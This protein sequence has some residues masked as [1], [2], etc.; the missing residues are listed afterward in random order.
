MKHTFDYHRAFNRSCSSSLLRAKMHFSNANICLTNFKVKQAVEIDGADF[1]I[2]SF[3]VGC[4]KQ[5]CLIS[6]KKR[7]FFSEITLMISLKHLPN[8][9]LTYDEWKN[10]E[11]HLFY[12]LMGIEEM[13]FVTRCY[14]H[15]QTDILSCIQI[16]LIHLWL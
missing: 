15:F 13:N 10:G 16:I 9:Q 14:S 11:R 8:L 4:L 6:I 7:S 5:I 12:D 1:I 2:A 3:A